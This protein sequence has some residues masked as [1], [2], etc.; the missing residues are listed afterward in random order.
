MAGLVASANFRAPK[1]ARPSL[2]S[3]NVGQLPLMAIMANKTHRRWLT[4][5]V[6]IEF[7]LC[8]VFARTLQVL[9]LKTPCPVRSAFG[10]LAWLSAIPFCA[11]RQRP[12]AH[13]PHIH[14]HHPPSSASE[15]KVVTSS[16][17]PH[18]LRL[19]HTAVVSHLCRT[20]SAGHVFPCQAIDIKCHRNGRTMPN[21]KAQ[22]A[23]CVH[24]TKETTL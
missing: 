22:S 18:V 14:H 19:S 16:A 12:M 21:A 5:P 11:H 1:L 9:G 15:A 23:F 10:D 4:R 2:Q 17:K 6:L 24:R 20:D 3:D 7:R 8:S 13:A